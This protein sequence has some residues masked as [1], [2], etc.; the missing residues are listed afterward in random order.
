MNKRIVLTGILT[1]IIDFPADCLWNESFL[2]RR[3]A[4]D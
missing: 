3:R 1:G 4:K 2:G